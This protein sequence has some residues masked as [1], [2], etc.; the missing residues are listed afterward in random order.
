MCYSLYT[1]SKLCLDSVRKSQ[2]WTNDAQDEREEAFYS[3]PLGLSLVIVII[4]VI[5]FLHLALGLVILTH[6]HSHLHRHH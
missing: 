4:I 3:S 1:L 2:W 6:P 5:I